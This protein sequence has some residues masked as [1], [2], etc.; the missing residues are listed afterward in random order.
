MTADLR[1]T[2]EKRQARAGSI[3]EGSPAEPAPRWWLPEGLGRGPA[4]R[5]LLEFYPIVSAIVV[6]LIVIDMLLD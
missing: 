2:A 6:A 1:G 4:S 3:V 5:L